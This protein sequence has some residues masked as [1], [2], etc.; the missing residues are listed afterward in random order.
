MALSV[1]L[2]LSDQRMSYPMAWLFNQL[3]SLYMGS[4]APELAPRHLLLYA[5]WFDRSDPDRPLFDPETEEFVRKHETL[6]DPNYLFN[7]FPPITNEN[8]D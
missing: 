7:I 2:R 3:T 6:S 5:T 8:T 1:Y 4:R